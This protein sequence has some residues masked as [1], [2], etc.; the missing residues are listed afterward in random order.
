MIQSLPNPAQCERLLVNTFEW[1]HHGDAEPGVITARLQLPS[2]S[3]LQDY[4]SSTG[5]DIDGYDQFV[6]TM[7]S[8]WRSGAVISYFDRK[9]NAGRLIHKVRDVHWDEP[10]LTVWMEHSSRLSKSVQLLER[11]G[12]DVV[13]PGQIAKHILQ[14]IGGITGVISNAAG[15]SGEPTVPTDA[16]TSDR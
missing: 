16:G 14:T 15:Q 8:D 1:A 3:R 10:I 13:V 5:F 6:N 12:L 7:V 9:L 11:G 4:L 2:F